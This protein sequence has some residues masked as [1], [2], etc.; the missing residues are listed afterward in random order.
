MILKDIPEGFLAI[1]V[2]K[3]QER[4]VV[5]VIYLNHPLFAQL[6]K[7]AEE[8]YGFAHQ[9]TLTIPCQME[10]FRYVQSIIESEESGI[11]QQ[12]RHLVCCFRV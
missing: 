6:L 9:G 11:Q 2:G 4:M 5:P 10:E 3:E 7:K 8:E 1:K 12:H